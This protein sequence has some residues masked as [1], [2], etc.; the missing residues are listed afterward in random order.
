MEAYER[1]QER[2]RKLLEAQEEKLR[3]ERD[4]IAE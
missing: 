1:E 4:A 3:K 2:L